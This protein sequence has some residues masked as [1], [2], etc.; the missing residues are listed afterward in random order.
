MLLLIIP[1]SLAFLQITEIMYN[2]EGQDNNREYI[3][4]HTNENLTNFILQD[5]TSE[6]S[7]IL[8]K[9]SPSDYSLIVEE[10]FNHSNID[11]RIYSAGATIGNN[12]NNEGDII[13]LKNQTSIFDTIHY[14]PSW[15]GDNNGKSLC[16]TDNIWNEC[17]PSPGQEQASEEN[18][19]ITINEFLPDPQGNDNAPM[20]EG[21][22]IELLNYGNKIDLADFYFKDSANHKLYITSTTT[23]NTTIDEFLVI[24]TN[25]FSGLL[26]NNGTEEIKFYTANGVLIESITYGSSTEGLS[27][28]KVNNKWKQALPTPHG[29]NEEESNFDSQLK[30]EKVYIGTDNKAKFGE[31]IR[32]KIVIYKGNTS[33][34][35]INAW[36]E[37]NKEPISKKT[38]VNIEKKYEEIGLTIPIQI[39]PN[40]KEKYSN[41]KYTLKI[42]GLNEVDTDTI[43]IDGI[44]KNLCGEAKCK[45]SK[46]NCPTYSETNINDPNSTTDTIYE[47]T[48]KKAERK[49]LVFF[50]MVLIFI[51]IQLNLEKWRK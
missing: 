45:E 3:E 46:T 42:E 44:T 49:G 4:I 23:Y 13:I 14:Y 34:E 43:T 33:K 26:N 50:C 11:A 36:I 16:L 32:A 5:S 2:P 31:T 20:P 38:K 8:V 24:Y 47:S 9:D 7:L 51:I 6:D 41:G 15:G 30:I 29:K 35:A 10:D 37:N 27:W 12:L 21:E 25:G 40:C 39:Y 1:N 28:S 22:W 48:N 19:N 17:S 18:Y